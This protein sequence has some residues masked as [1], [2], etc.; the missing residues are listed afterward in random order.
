MTDDFK[1]YLGK[2]MPD[3][4]YRH[5]LSKMRGGLGKAIAS[6]LFALLLIG[7]ADFM[8]LLT[9]DF[10]DVPIAIWI[11]E[12]LVFLFFSIANIQGICAKEKVRNRKFRWRE[13][14]VDEV[15]Y[16]QNT[17]HK[18]TRRCLIVDGICCNPPENLGNF[19]KGMPVIV[20]NTGIEEQYAFTI[21]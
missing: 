1:W 20:V 5:I 8:I 17:G 11:I 7:G 13:G 3:I 12:A 18:N 10:E 4:Q 21:K 15:V 16:T 2:D 9:S 19:K 6:E 14:T